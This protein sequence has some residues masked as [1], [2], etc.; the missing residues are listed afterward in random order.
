M[1]A[2]PKSP[3]VLALIFLCGATH[4]FAPKV[5]TLLL[6]RHGDSVWNGGED[7]YPERFTGWSDV[8][9]SKLGKNEAHQAASTLASYIHDVDVCF[10]ST[11]SRALETAQV[12]LDVLNK[13]G[14]Y[15]PVLRDARLNERHYGAL[16]GLIKKGVEQGK[17]GHSPELVQ[18]WRRSW[19]VRPPAM[20]ADDPR[21]AE[22]IQRHGY[23]PNGESLEMV[24]QDRI[25]PFL[26]DTLLP[27]VE[28][29]VN[30]MTALVVAHANSLRALI[31][32]MCSVQSN[33]NAL[34]ILESLRV[35]TGV[36]L[37]LNFEY[38]AHYGPHLLDVPDPDECVVHEGS[39]WI[40]RP[41]AP[42]PDLGHPALRVWPLNRCIP[43]MP[44][45][46][47]GYRLR[48][49]SRGY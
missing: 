9:L 4:S 10:T 3:I 36:P 37:V 17:Y 31:G 20:K 25:R 47:T 26:A 35:P 46:Y 24:A 29:S 41:N 40:R 34:S 11:L 23:S 21:L 22:E 7:G 1:R 32:V 27:M 13:Q 48:Q 5:H 39:G 45:V 43:T 16:Q 33:R 12:C 14:K 44:K 18:Q 19:H 6:C 38:H 30:S 2:L 28:S 8:P 49:H 15:P 42:P